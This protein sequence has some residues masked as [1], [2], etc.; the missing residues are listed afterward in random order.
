MTTDQD[1][2]LLRD[3]QTTG[4]LLTTGSS[5]PCPSGDSPYDNCRRRMTGDRQ[6]TSGRRLDIEHEWVRLRGFAAMV[7]DLQP[8]MGLSD[9]NLRNLIER[10]KEVLG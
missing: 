10:A 2:A 1:A 3:R 6:A 8:G 5:C 7:A 4:C 9:N